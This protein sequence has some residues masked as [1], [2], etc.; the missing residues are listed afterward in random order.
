MQE[1]QAWQKIGKVEYRMYVNVLTHL[2][3]SVNQAIRAMTIVFVNDAL[4]SEPSAVLC[5]GQVMMS[6]MNEEGNGS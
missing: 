2:D 4:K 3:D 5:N 1:V 6:E